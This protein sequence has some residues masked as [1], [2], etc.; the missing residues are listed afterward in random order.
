MRSLSEAAAA[1]GATVATMAVHPRTSSVGYAD[2]KLAVSIFAIV[3]EGR[4]GAAEAVE[5]AGCC[6]GALDEAW[7]TMGR[8]GARGGYLD[9]LSPRAKMEAT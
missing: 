2:L 9:F 5:E 4:P 8:W 3:S 6:E 1:L 7:E